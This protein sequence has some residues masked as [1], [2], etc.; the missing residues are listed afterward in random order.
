MLPGQDIFR[1]I[2]AGN[3]PQVT[4]SLGR[5]YA[6]AKMWVNR[7]IVS[8]RVLPAVIIGFVVGKAIAKM[9]RKRGDFNRILKKIISL[10][11]ILSYEKT[12]SSLLI[13][14]NIKKSLLGLAL[15]SAHS[16]PLASWP[17]DQLQLKFQPL[18]RPA[19]TERKRGNFPQ[20]TSSHSTAATHTSP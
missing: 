7:E 4:G 17:A 2:S 8:N 3:G 19:N 16:P 10:A 12:S 20:N 15:L 6:L 13:I 1:R 14:S 11:S 9:L 18:F 5:L